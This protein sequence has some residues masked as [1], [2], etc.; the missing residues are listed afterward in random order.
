[1]DNAYLN[2]S[3]EGAKILFG[4]VAEEKHQD[5]DPHYHLCL[6]ADKKHKYVAIFVVIPWTINLFYSIA[7][8]RAHL[9]PKE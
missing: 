5:G 7:T 1:M 9:P 8:S 6:K 4:C 3:P 2:G